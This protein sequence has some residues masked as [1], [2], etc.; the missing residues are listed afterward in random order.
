MNS[1]DSVEF[2]EEIPLLSSKSYFRIQESD[3]FES[4]VR[5]FPWITTSIREGTFTVGLHY[6]DSNEIQ[7][8]ITGQPPRSCISVFILNSANPYLVSV[9]FFFNFFPPS[10]VTIQEIKKNQCALLVLNSHSLAI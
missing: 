6:F 8:G 9:E 7:Y 2:L 3:S 4:F 5:Q 1:T 10:S